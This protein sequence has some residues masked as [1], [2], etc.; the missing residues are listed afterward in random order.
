MSGQEPLGAVLAGGRSRRFGSNKALALFRDET[1]LDRAARALEPV[2]PDVVVVG[3]GA[4]LEDRVRWRIVPDA[5]PDAGPL[6][7][8]HAALLEAR[9]EGGEGVLLV[10]CDM[11]LLTPLLLRRVLRAGRESGQTAAV[12][13]AGGG[14]LQPL[15]AWYSTACFPVVEERLGSPD[16][17]LRGLLGAID[18]HRIPLEALAD[19]G[20]PASRVALRLRSVNTR[21]ELAELDEAFPAQSP[22]HTPPAVSIIGY[23]ESGKTGTA[24]AL[25]AELRRRRY[26]VGAIKHGHGFRLDTPGT[27]SWRLRHE[28]GAERVLLSGPEGFAL[29][30]D[31]GAGDEADVIPLLRSHMAEME[32]V[33]V[34]GFKRGPLPA[35]EVFR[36]GLHPEPF[37]LSG[38]GRRGR[39]LAL[40]SDREGLDRFGE[41]VRS[42]VSDGMSLF[43]LD[44]PELS[45]RLADLTE[46]EVMGV[47]R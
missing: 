2:C 47:E 14:G 9:R 7:G 21:A 25:T 45:A 23:K 8:L 3:R 26:Q 43:R 12:P 41:A 27:D 37:V 35:I 1:L 36:S 24:V 29:M 13:L 33:V 15:C 20:E 34:E 6:G 46:R 18:A 39:W 17:S 4:E 28:G 5:V 32:V 30:G 19:P 11:P 42:R 16:R 31:W 40:V 22:V 44:D 10:A 38:D